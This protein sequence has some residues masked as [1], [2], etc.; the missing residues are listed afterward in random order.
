[1]ARR[2]WGFSDDTSTA[3]SIYIWLKFE[4]W[5]VEMEGATSNL[6]PS[7]RVGAEL[8]NV[9]PSCEGEQSSW[10]IPSSQMM[11][12]GSEKNPFATNVDLE[13]QNG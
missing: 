10:R 3:I 11:L 7:G 4:S 5:G 12:L 6:T 1:M 13:E 8:V 2:T 9:G